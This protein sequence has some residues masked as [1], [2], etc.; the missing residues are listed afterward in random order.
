[1]TSTDRNKF[2]RLSILQPQCFPFGG[3]LEYRLNCQLYAKPTIKRSKLYFK[4]SAWPEHCQSL[5][6]IIGALN[7]L[8]GLS[9]LQLWNFLMFY[10]LKIFRKLRKFSVARIQTSN[11]PY[12]I[13]SHFFDFFRNPFELPSNKGGYQRNSV[14]FS[15]KSFADES[16]SDHKLLYHVVQAWENSPR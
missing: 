11:N 2:T 1:M 13:N 9:F 10:A 16:M 3:T 15:K 12:L 14:G 7:P 8:F 4:Q 6:I 5:R